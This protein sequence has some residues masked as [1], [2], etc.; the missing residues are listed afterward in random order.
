MLFTRGE[1]SESLLFS[2]KRYLCCLLALI[3]WFVSFPVSDLSRTLFD[4]CVS[5][6]HSTHDEQGL[7]VFVLFNSISASSAPNAT[8]PGLEAGDHPLLWGWNH[9]VAWF[10]PEVI[11]RARAGLKLRLDSLAVLLCSLN[12]AVIWM[13]AED[14]CVFAEPT[15]PGQSLDWGITRESLL[16][17][18]SL[19]ASSEAR[20]IAR[21][22]IQH[23]SPCWVS[24]W[25]VRDLIKQA[26]NCWY[27]HCS[28]RMWCAFLLLNR[29]NT[30]A[31]VRW[32]W[33]EHM[34][35][36]WAES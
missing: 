19:V 3:I 2:Q 29:A 14:L 7:D 5:Y 4:W 13:W 33:E 17:P 22:R 32:C 25:E 6:V 12:L 11:N 10:P 31:S 16:P 30:G 24:F 26:Q 28:G 34:G 35:R 1:G 8:I 9:H 36:S 15:V 23:L 27:K 21:N 18:A 20:G